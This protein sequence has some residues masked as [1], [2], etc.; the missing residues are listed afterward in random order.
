MD[1]FAKNAAE[2]ALRKMFRPDGWLDI[3]LID[4][5]VK[6]AGVLPPSGEYQSMRLLHCVHWKEMGADVRNEAARR[7]LSWFTLPP[8]DPWPEVKPAVGVL[9]RLL[10]KVPQ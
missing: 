9:N 2:I 1:D 3:C 5:L 4:Q 7:I 6:V 8:F 10:G